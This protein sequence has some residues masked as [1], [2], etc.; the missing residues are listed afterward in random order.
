[1]Y[2][3]TLNILNAGS[4]SLS[5]RVCCI[6]RSPNNRLH[7]IA[8]ALIFKFVAT[9]VMM[10]WS[11]FG[12]RLHDVSVS[13]ALVVSVISVY[14]EMFVH[15]FH[16]CQRRVMWSRTKRVSFT[17]F[18]TELHLYQK[19]KPTQFRWDQVQEHS[20]C[21]QFLTNEATQKKIN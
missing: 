6:F 13:V 7:Q 4:Y 10:G 12:A 1:M 18:K 21:R 9:W 15:L 2:V 11:V 20:S 19:N 5:K 14:I 8:M 16:H 17:F 3:G